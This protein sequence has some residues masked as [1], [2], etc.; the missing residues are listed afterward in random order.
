M[1]VFVNPYLLMD[2]LEKPDT[3]KTKL[4]TGPCQHGI[5]PRRSGKF[6]VFLEEYNRTRYPEYCLGTYLLSSDLVHKIVEMFDANK[7][8]FKIEDV[9]IGML[10]EKID[11]VKAIRHRSFRHFRRCDLFPNVFAQHLSSAKCMGELFNLA[12]KKKEE[13]ELRKT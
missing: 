7:Q 13:N 8:P 5:A 10:V 12:M 9:Y 6:K 4:Y 1:N 2:Y 3:P 11:D